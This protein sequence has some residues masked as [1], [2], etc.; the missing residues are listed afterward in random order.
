MTTT[1]VQ[2]GRPISEEDRRKKSLQHLTHYGLKMMVRTDIGG[3]DKI[4]NLPKYMA[5]KF[6]G[7]TAAEAGMIAAEQIHSTV[8]GIK[9]RQRRTIEEI[10]RR[11]DALHAA[12]QQ[13]YRAHK[14]GDY[15]KACGILCRGIANMLIGE[16]STIPSYEQMMDDTAPPEPTAATHILT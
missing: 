11:D 10:D 7:K 12:L 16:G 5:D 3:Q 13:A 4:Q 14:K 9:E 1:E 15:K 6:V 2:E 8:K